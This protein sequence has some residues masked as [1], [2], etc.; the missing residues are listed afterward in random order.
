MSASLS[1][2]FRTRHA[3]LVWQDC[4]HCDRPHLFE[5]QER[6]DR[7]CHVCGFPGTD[8]E[9]HP[10]DAVM[11]GPFSRRVRRLRRGLNYWTER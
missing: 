2:P 5:P 7:F 8:R 1:Y 6:D 3:L 10:S 9:I 11:H 4:M